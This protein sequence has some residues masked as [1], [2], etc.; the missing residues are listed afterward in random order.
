MVFVD[1]EI[2]R[3]DFIQFN[4]STGTFSKFLPASAIVVFFTACTMVGYS[5]CDLT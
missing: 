4:A 5:L 2:D 3:I 1:F